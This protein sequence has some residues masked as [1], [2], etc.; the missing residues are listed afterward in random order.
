M[1]INVKNQ[2][3][4][5]K[6]GYQVI[7]SGIGICL[8]EDFRGLKGKTDTIL[9]HLYNHCDLTTDDLNDFNQ[10]SEV[11]DSIDWEIA[12]CLEEE[13]IDLV[14]DILPEG[15]F[16]GYNHLGDLGIWLDES[17]EVYK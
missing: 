14:N 3:E 11:K 13:Y 9:K 17:E 12:F 8:C 1:R 2:I 10:V 7:N 16:M 5:K 6:L 15:S 4:L